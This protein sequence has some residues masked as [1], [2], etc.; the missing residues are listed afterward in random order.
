MQQPEA[1]TQAG[2]VQQKLLKLQKLLSNFYK[3]LVRGNNIES[4]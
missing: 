1:G 3:F 4:E 2:K